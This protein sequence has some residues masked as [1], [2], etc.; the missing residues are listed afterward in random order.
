MTDVSLA[1]E[2]PPKRA[3]L[4]P[5]QAILKLLIN[6]YKHRFSKRWTAAVMPFPNG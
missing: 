2:K 3:V 5:K 6:I 4:H 1:A